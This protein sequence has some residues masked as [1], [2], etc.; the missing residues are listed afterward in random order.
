MKG[1]LIILS[2]VSYQ[3]LNAQP[4]IEGGNTRHRFAQLTL[5]TQVTALN[6]QATWGVQ[7]QL[8]IGGTHFWGHADF[9]LAVP[10]YQLGDSKM[11]PGV[12]TAM[13]YFPWRITSRRISPYVGSSW[14]PM[15]YQFGDGAPLTLHRFPIGSGL[16]YLS[17]QFLIGLHMNYF[18]QNSFNY[19]ISREDIGAL[20]HQKFSWSLSAKWMIESTLSAEK[21][22]K[23]GRTAKLTDTLAKLKRLN[24]L[25]FSV[26][27]SSA[28][29]LGSVYQGGWN[30]LDQGKVMRVFPEFGVGYYWH[31]PDVQVNLAY[32]GYKL[33][34]KA[35]GDESKWL[36]RS[37]GLEMFKFIGDYHGFVPFIGLMAS[38]EQ[39]GLAIEAEGKAGEKFEDA[40]MHPGLVFGWDIRP[41]RLQ[42]FYLRTTLRWHPTLELKGKGNYFELDQLEFNFIQ[43]VIFPGRW[44]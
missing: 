28:T 26:G 18:P 32:R 38:Y 4:Y 36:R 17:K 9:L 30:H 5:G 21:E 34:S 25:T 40:G 31:N 20:Y 13:R 7:Q 3:F 29:T 15:R 16:Q 24:G 11:K 14:Q 10:F 8:I 37:L 41:N 2:L 39:L 1:I 44:R 22:W 6:T 27:I 19:S 12:E 42:A 23:S 35:F 43:L 33:Q